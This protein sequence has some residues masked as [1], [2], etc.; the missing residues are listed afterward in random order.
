[1]KL[2]K[3]SD[4][5]NRAGTADAFI[6]SEEIGERRYRYAAESSEGDGSAVVPG[7]LRG[8]AAVAA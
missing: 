2:L 6:R 7:S 1:M 8:C 5:R 3:P 4:A